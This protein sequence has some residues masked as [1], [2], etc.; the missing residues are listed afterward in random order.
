LIFI[1]IDIFTIRLKEKAGKL[2]EKVIFKMKKI[3]KEMLVD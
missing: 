3:L 1:K 2:N